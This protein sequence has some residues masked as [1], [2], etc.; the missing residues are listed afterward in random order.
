MNFQPQVENIEKGWSLKSSIIWFFFLS[1]F[2]STFAIF[3]YKQSSEIVN[4]FSIY[5]SHL[6][7]PLINYF[8]EKKEAEKKDV[9]GKWEEIWN[10]FHNFFLNYF[11]NICQKN[12][13][14]PSKKKVFWDLRKEIKDYGWQNFLA[15]F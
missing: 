3:S 5:A 10:F 6:L 12:C 13:E 8:I 1:A 9:D 15:S 14:F 11:E 4:F 7:E 2:R